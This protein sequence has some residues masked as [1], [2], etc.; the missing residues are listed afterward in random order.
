MDGPLLKEATNESKCSL[1][2]NKT[3][4]ADTFESTT[5]REKFWNESKL[6]R[7]SDSKI[8]YQERD[9]PKTVRGMTDN[10]MQKRLK[11]TVEQ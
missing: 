9:R 3:T 7:N 2:F 6:G 4:N 10:E 11:E 5:R 1:L 8:G